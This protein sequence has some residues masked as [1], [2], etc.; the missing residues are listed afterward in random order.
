MKTCP[1]SAELVRSGGWAGC[2]G[3]GGGCPMPADMTTWLAPA[4][5]KAAPMKAVAKGVA[6]AAPIKPAAAGPVKKSHHKKG[7]Y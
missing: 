6:K 5:P 1:G 4:A 2:G 7:M 3:G